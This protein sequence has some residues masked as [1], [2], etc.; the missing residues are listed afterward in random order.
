MHKKLYLVLE[1]V[2]RGPILQT[3]HWVAISEEKARRHFRDICRGL[4]YLHYHKV[5]LPLATLSTCSNLS[6]YR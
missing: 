3:D 5:Q 1:Y 6:M 2:E 4:D